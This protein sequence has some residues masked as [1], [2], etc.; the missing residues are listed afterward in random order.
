MVNHFRRLSARGAGALSCWRLE[1][2]AAELS[3]L[4]GPAAAA[5]GPERVR[6]G[7]AGDEWDE[8]LL[9]RPPGGGAELHL[10]GGA[11]VAQALRAWL[12]ARGWQEEA[13]AA[14]AALPPPELPDA[15]EAGL[16]FLQ[17]DS[18][19]AARAWSEFARRDAPQTLAEGARLA[20]APRA[21]WAREQ[22]RH[23]AWAAA[24]ETPPALVLAGPPN[25]GKSSLFNAWL[26]SARATVADAPGTTRDLVG[27]RL[28]L[29]R[30][31]G[32]W[33]LQLVDTAGLWDE[34]AGTDLLAIGRTQAALASA[35]KTLWVL[36]A[37]AP[38]G[39]LLRAA[40]EQ[41][42]PGD[43]LLLHR[44]DLAAV[45]DPIA[46]ASGPWLRGSI[47]QEGEG[48][49]SRLE[50]ALAQSLGPEPGA[51]AWLPLGRGLRERLQSGAEA[52]PPGG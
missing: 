16:R 27:E 3:A 15:A 12:Q 36:D 11:G 28:S 44:T 13:A 7:P 49:L 52:A 25:A 2:P 41:R 14:S 1:A 51:A 46:L 37:A 38:P 45:W 35:W 34:A 24:L 42:R 43:L 23:A 30:G 20:G 39:R 21:A 47:L 18:P 40:L 33:S 50:A 48:L 19:R 29:G 32:A 10:H 22:L 31:S 8:G 6:L 26:R 17:A 5:G 4:F 9:W